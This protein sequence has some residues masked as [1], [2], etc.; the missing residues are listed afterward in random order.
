MQ[1][2][3]GGLVGQNNRDTTVPDAHPTGTIRASYATGD[4]IGTG[5]SRVAGGLVGTNW[6]GASI[7]ASY[8]TGRV[9]GHGRRKT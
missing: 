3:I 4:V 1:S 9:V 6:D 2:S 8:A 7:R 5:M